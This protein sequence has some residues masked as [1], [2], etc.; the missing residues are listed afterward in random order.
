M[1]GIAWERVGN[2]SGRAEIATCDGGGEDLCGGRNPVGR[3]PWVAACDGEGSHAMVDVDAAAEEVVGRIEAEDRDAREE[4]VRIPSEVEVPGGMALPR[5]TSGAGCISCGVGG[6]GGEVG[7]DPARA[8]RR[9]HRVRV[10]RSPEGTGET[11]EA[12][13]LAGSSWSLS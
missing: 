11:G 5:G 4:E 8:A 2:G 7:A 10:V 12:G 3:A 9:V 1:S 13:C 6:C